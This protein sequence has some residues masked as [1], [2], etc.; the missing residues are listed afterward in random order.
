MRRAVGAARP[1]AGP[2]AVL[3]KLRQGVRHRGADDVA[4]SQVGGVDGVR[5]LLP[6][7]QVGEVVVLV[8]HQVGRGLLGLLVGAHVDDWR[9]ACAGVGHAEY[10]D[11]SGLKVL[12]QW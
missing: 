5:D 12:V 3:Q 1:G 6:G 10:V 8:D 2:V 11:E 9:R 7:G 4:C